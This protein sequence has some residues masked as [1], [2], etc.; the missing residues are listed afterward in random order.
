MEQKKI[1]IVRSNSVRPDSRVEKEAFALTQA[2]YKVCILAWD[3]DKNHLPTEGSINVAGECLPITWLGHQATYGEGFKNIVPYIK[4]QI[5]MC[6]WLIKKRECYSII[7]ACDFDTAFFSS[8]IAH[9]LKKKMVFDIFDFL[10]GEPQNLMQLIV[11]KAQIKIINRAEGTIICS[12]ERKKQIAGAIP[13]KLAVIHNT[14]FLELVR[15]QEKQEEKTAKIKVAYVGILQDYRLLLEI[16]DYFTKH[17]EVEFHIGGFGKYESYFEKLA[18]QYDNIKFYGRMKYEDTLE[19]E[20]NCDVMTAIYDPSIENHRFA[21]P[22]KFYESLMLGKPVIMVENTGMSEVVR[23]HDIGV[24]I[25]YSQQGFEKGLNEL[26]S[27][28][29]EWEVIGARMKRLYET[30]YSWKEM[31]KRLIVFYE[32]I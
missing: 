6:K 17:R 22:N 26:L 3:R 25:E 24:L 1:C 9:L 10:Y 7:H 28:K 8:K 32:T 27:R 13:K 16:A 31:E 11:K 29:S 18:Q 21:A 2:G 12:E 5:N 20:Q 30:N 14:P 19:L 4:F 23:K 15:K